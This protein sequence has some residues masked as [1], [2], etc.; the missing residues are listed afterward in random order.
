MA[1]HPLFCSLRH[2]LRNPL[3]GLLLGSS[4]EA[5]L[6]LQL[7]VTLLLLDEFA[8]LGPHDSLAKSVLSE[9][10]LRE[11]ALR[12]G[13]KVP[14]IPHS[15]FFSS[16]LCSLLHDLSHDLSLEIDGSGA[17]HRQRQCRVLV[18]AIVVVRARHR[19]LLLW[20]VDSSVSVIEHFVMCD[21]ILQ[22]SMTFGNM[23]LRDSAALTGELAHGLFL[24]PVT[25][26]RALASVGALV[27]N[28]LG[29]FKNF[30]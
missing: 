30:I 22:I 23:L 15:L 8:V 27:E 21:R 28:I 6:H 25:D 10:L 12:C 24:L 13:V 17:L 1:Q 29:H 3:V 14:H 26:E 20:A 19:H 18:L 7:L 11:G 9:I 4:K 2:L 5:V 16:L